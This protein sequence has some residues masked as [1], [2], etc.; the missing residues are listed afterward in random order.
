MCCGVKQNTYH[1]LQVRRWVRVRVRVRV[2]VGVGVG[3]GVGVR[4]TCCGV[5]CCG[6]RVRCCG[7]R[8]RC[9]GVKQNPHHA[10]QDM[11]VVLTL[12]PRP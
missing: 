6:V 9:C 5:R 7:V 3:V 11:R 12:T 10:L 8:V 2:R 4:V 1:T